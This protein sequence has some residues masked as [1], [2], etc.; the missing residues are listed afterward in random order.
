[1]MLPI[2]IS[3]LQ[4]AESRRDNGPAPVT[5]F[6]IVMVLSIASARNIGGIG[7]L[8][9]TPPNALMAAFILEN[10]GVEISFAQW[11]L[12]GFPLVLI[13]LPIMYLL[14]SRFIFP[15]RIKELPG[16]R[17]IILKHIRNLG[18][19]SR[20]VFTVAIVFVFTSLLW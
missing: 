18:S 19:M 11:M 9:A 4:F 5:N 1:M 12:V 10:Y 2:A 6:W 20:P 15:I 8:I 14:L 16:G 7:I 17:E 3:V 13:M